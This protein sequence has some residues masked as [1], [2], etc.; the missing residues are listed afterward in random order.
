MKIHRIDLKNFFLLMEN[1]YLKIMYLSKASCSS[2]DAKK[3]HF[4][5]QILAYVL[6]GGIIDGSHSDDERERPSVSYEVDKLIDQS[7]FTWL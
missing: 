3:S 6:R 5:P 2:E 4:L 1:Y 7:D